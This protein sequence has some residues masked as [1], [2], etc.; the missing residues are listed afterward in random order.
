MPPPPPQKRFLPPL[1]N[2]VSSEIVKT[3]NMNV[4]TNTLQTGF[5]CA[6]GFGTK[7][8][9]KR[10]RYHL[11]LYSTC[12]LA[13]PVAYRTATVSGH[14]MEGLLLFQGE[15]STSFPYKLT[16]CHR[17]TFSV[18]VYGPLAFCLNR[19]TA[20]PCFSTMQ[21]RGVSPRGSIYPHTLWNKIHAHKLNH[22]KRKMATLAVTINCHATL[23]LV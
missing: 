7:S 13:K 1:G 2:L 11:A 22:C 5:G 16:C 23:F 20:R 10:V 19:L 12:R 18:R 8:V 15:S 9:T 3:K 6:L 17:F 14:M 21:G 4:N